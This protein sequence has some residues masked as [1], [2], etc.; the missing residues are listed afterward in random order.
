MTVVFLVKSSMN[1]I[2][3]LLP[4]KD[5]TGI[6]PQR[7]ECISSQTSLLCLP[8][9]FVQAFFVDFPMLHA[10]QLY[11]SIIVLSNP[12]TLLYLANFSIALLFT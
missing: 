3:Y 6:G 10:S 11:L 2:K 5:L 1:V 4:L 9:I 7:S 8:L 12:R